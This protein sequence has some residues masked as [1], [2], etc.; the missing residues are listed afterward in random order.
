MRALHPRTG[1]WPAL[2]P[3]P[4]CGGIRQSGDGTGPAERLAAGLALDAESLLNPKGSFDALDDRAVEAMLG[5]WPDEDDDEEYGPERIDRTAL[6]HVRGAP[7]SAQVALIEAEEGWQVP[8]LLDFGGWNQC[9]EPPAHPPVLRRW[10][11]RY[12]AEVV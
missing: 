3:V 8:T 6:T 1:V 2:V 12:G 9:P 10:Y 5:E 7:A 4:P 11:E